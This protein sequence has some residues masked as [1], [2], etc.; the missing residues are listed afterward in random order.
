MLI[1]TI[2]DLASV[3]QTR[4]R[5]AFLQALLNDYITF[6]DA[7]YPADYDRLLTP[8]DAGYVVP[9]LRKEWNAGA[10]AAWGFSSQDQIKAL[11]HA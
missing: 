1:N 2:E 10:A 11:L 8:S 9:V 4:E 3:D 5:Q 6:D 7:S